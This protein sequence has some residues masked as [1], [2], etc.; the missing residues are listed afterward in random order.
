MLAGLQLTANWGTTL[1]PRAT[2]NEPSAS[3]P[4]TAKRTAGWGERRPRNP[5][6]FLSF[7][8]NWFSVFFPVWL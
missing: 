5:K 6:E 4:P 7:L 1:K 3:T 2:V 8:F